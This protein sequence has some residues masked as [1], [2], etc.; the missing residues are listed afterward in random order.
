MSMI[1]LSEVTKKYG[2]ERALDGITLRIAPR[3]R[4]VIEGP[5]GSGKSTLLR[6]IAGLAAPD[7][8]T[9]SLDGR[10]VSAEGRIL[11]PPENRG[12]GMVFQ[13][14]ALWPHL[15]VRSNLEFGLKARHVRATERDKLVRDI[16]G[17]VN[18]GDKSD[19]RPSELSGGQ[20]QRVALARALVL[21]P[22]IV[23]MDEPLSHLDP[24]LAIRLRAEIVRLQEDRGFTLVYVTHLRDEAQAI[25]TRIV[26]MQDGVILGSCG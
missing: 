8:G 15:S 3:E 12:I 17:L 4:V 2:A 18:L 11:V 25:G 19:V 1:D 7:S 10:V 5:S 6:M 16:L 13:D 9:L 23:L 21:D 20:Q 22:K 14:L 24:E 26:V